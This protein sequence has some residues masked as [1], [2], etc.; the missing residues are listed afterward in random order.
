M[1]VYN[2]KVGDKN[3]KI[4][5]SKTSEDTFT[6]KIGD[7]T[8]EVKLKRNEKSK[9]A[10]SI[11]IDGNEY[12]VEAPKV[13]RREPFTIRVD[14][15]DFNVQLQLPERKIAYVSPSMPSVTAASRTAKAAA[16]PVVEGA[17][18]APMTGKIV[19][20]R[21][22]EGDSVKEGQVV[23]VLEAMKMENEIMAP[24]SGRVKE[25]RVSEGSAVNE[26]EVLLI[27]E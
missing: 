18:T 9:D 25:I 2:M 16:F 1:P 19:S 21:V 6:V 13:S 5:I 14:D 12:R 22:K 26:G 4:E 17:V 11:T 3:F 10:F 8:H 15:V 24:K 23:C 27:I 20:I 7:K